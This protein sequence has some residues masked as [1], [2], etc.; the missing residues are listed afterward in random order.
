MFCAAITWRTKTALTPLPGDPDS[1]RG[2]VTGRV[3]LECLQ[4]ILPTICEPG[5]IYAQD[6]A[7]THTARVVQ[8]WLVEW[9]QENGVELVKWPPSSPDLNPIGN[10]WKVLRERICAEY[11]NLADMPKNLASWDALIRAAVNIWED[12]EEQLLRNLVESMDS[13]MR[14]VYRCAGGAQNTKEG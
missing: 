13:R 4:D 7:S 6:N 2:G 9:A 12:I 3:I 10:L 1:A 14:A 11:P 5:S 8:N